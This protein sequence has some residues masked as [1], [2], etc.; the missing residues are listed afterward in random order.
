[1]G[2][3]LWAVRV[4]GGMHIKII[5]LSIFPIISLCWSEYSKLTS[6]W[7]K[8]FNL[9]DSLRWP[10]WVSLDIAPWLVYWIFVVKEATINT[11]LQL[12]NP[13]SLV[14][15]PHKNNSVRSIEKIL[16]WV[17]ITTSLMLQNHHHHGYNN[18]HSSG[19]LTHNVAHW[20]QTSLS[21]GKFLCFL[22]H[23]SQPPPN[24]DFLTV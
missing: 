7:K 15:L 20:N 16:V 6:H 17:L 1:M 3:C 23:V 2:G 22:I 12:F 19:T 14:T 8:S 9:N 21:R 13:D 18:K 4:V 5:A 11:W 10:V 24:A